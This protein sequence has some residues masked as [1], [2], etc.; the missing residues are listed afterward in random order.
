M[1]G[2]FVLYLCYYITYSFENHMVYSLK[3]G[4]QFIFI[5]GLS[6]KLLADNFEI[7][8]TQTNYEINLHL[9]LS[10]NFRTRNKMEDKYQEA[11]LLES[12]IESIEYIQITNDQSL[13]NLKRI[14]DGIMELEKYRMFLNIQLRKATRLEIRLEGDE[15]S[16]CLVKI[17]K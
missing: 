5:E 4:S 15:N 1:V 6:I 7:S 2:A 3:K 11:E 14:L 12:S 8:I 10:V 17:N 16:L 13:K 9:D